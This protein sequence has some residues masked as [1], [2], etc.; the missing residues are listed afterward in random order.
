MLKK[1]LIA[2]LPLGTIAVVLWLILPQYRALQAAKAER[3]AA[4][5]ALQEKQEL[6][7]KIEELK[8]QYL[9]VEDVTD[10]VAQIVPRTPDIP[11]L[12]VEMPA[13][14]VQYGV[15][16]DN[17]SFNVTEN[18]IPGPSQD[19]SRPFQS[20]TVGLSVSGTYDAFQEYLKALE[21]ELRVLDVQSLQFSLPPAE[22][23]ASSIYEFKV[24]A[25]LYY[26][27]QLN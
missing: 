18:T 9:A 6:I 12:L 20:M 4:R 23:D 8:K 1:L 19:A 24:D 13:L 22:G 26:G 5:Q 17:I 16:L 2:I 27:L 21:R 3:E 14:A 7:A 25:Q 11:N 10:E 15:A